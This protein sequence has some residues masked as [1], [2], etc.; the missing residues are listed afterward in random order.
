MK[1]T[2]GKSCDLNTKFATI[3]ERLQ[4]NRADNAKL[5]PKLRHKLVKFT[6]QLEVDYTL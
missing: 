5:R 2:Y 1:P 6:P 3:G 4:L